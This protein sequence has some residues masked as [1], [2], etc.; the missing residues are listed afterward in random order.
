MD[1]I[2]KRVS[3]RKFAEKPIENEKL[4]RL[5]RAAMAAPSAGNQQPWEFYVTT[6]PETLAGLSQCSPYAKPTA[7]AALAI[8]PAMRT[9]GVHFPECAMQD[10]SA[11][12]ENILLEAVQLDLGAVWQAVAPFD[13]RVEKVRA[14]LD[15]PQNLEP[16]CII[17][18]GYPAQAIP[19]QK[20]R[21]DE[22]RIHL[23]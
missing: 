2:F 13:D 18:L 14:I 5:L 4:E 12:T 6:N 23:M 19:N 1:P 9:E 22:D 3:V 17:A 11:A 10:M 15:M 7:R 8:V 21:F 16:F 20:D